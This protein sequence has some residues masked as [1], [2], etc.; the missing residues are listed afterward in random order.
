MNTFVWMLLSSSYSTIFCVF[1]GRIWTHGIGGGA[2]QRYRRVDFKRVGPKEG[3]ATEERVIQVR[4]DPCRTADIAVVAGGTN[5][6]YIIASQNMKAGD[7]IKT[8]GKVTRIA[9]KE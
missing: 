2:K 8:S 6:R 3:P 1:S 5:K 9:G 7:I 4:Y